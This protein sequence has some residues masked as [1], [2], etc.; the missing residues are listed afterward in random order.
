MTIDQEIQRFLRESGLPPTKFGR[1]AVKDPRL[2][3]DMRNGRQLGPSVTA[4]VRRFIAEH[5][6]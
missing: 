5:Q 2:V 4:R 1:L 6:A 3:G